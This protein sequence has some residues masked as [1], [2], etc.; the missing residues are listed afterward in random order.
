MITSSI[1]GRLSFFH[2]MGV[3]YISK[4]SETTEKTEPIGYVEIHKRRFIIGI[5]YQHFLRSSMIHH[6]QAGEPQKPVL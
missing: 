4:D 5:G 3:Y 1:S 2:N 6:L